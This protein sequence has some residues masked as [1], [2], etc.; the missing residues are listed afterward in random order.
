MKKTKEIPKLPRLKCPSEKVFKDK[1]GKRVKRPTQE[2]LEDV[3][4]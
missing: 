4:G 3:E 2:E 1:K